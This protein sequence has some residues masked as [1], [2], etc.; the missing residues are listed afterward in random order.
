MRK[1]CVKSRWLSL[2]DFPGFE[3]V[4]CPDGG[5]PFHIGGAVIDPASWSRYLPG[6]ETP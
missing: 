6:K 1:L 5:G 2:A 3:L 4:G